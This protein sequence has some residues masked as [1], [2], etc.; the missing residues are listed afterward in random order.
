MP[1]KSFFAFAWALV[2]LSVPAVF[3]EKGELK[4][5]STIDWTKNK[6]TSS[7]MLD[8]DKA[9]IFMPSGKM[10]AVNKINTE[11]PDLVKDPLL[12]L[13]VDS[14]TVLADLVLQDD[15]TLEEITQIVDRGAKT[16]GVFVNETS[17]LKIVHT[18]NTLNISSK[19][20]RHKYPYK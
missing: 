9:G 19:M 3:A 8:M 1:K 11:L 5:E 10:T 16:P 6:F 18:I 17:T 15:L 2:F 13:C 4:S 7:V 12:S 14:D 20:V